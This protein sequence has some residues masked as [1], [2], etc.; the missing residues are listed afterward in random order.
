MEIIELSP[1][2]HDSD[3]VSRMIF[4][5][6]WWSLAAKCRTNY[7]GLRRRLNKPMNTTYHGS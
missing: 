1:D 3:G 6:E 4:W 5:F 7:Y 2:A